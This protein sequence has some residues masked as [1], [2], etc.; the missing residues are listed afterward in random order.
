MNYSIIKL[1]GLSMKPFF[2]TADL[3][4]VK[5]IEL[6][7]SILHGSCIYQNSLVH[8][9]VKAQALKGDRILSYDQVP[10]NERSAFLVIGR[11]ISHSPTLKVSYHQHLILRFISQIISILSKLNREK[12]PLRLLILALIISTSN[13]HRF[14]E[15]F[16]IYPNKIE[17]K[18]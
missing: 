3:V 5:K 7:D 16:I 18:E 8:R 1:E 14:L 2:K 17:I 12:N 4:V 15:F 9:L 10:F 13:M 11:I 6:S